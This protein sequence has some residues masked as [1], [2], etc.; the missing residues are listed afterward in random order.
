MPIKQRS[1]IQK[2]KCVEAVKNVI[3]MTQ[4]VNKQI[5]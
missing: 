4:S 2:L 1:L 5:T 3:F